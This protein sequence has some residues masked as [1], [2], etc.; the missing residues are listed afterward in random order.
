[1]LLYA[2]CIS[3][4]VRYT[5]NF[6]FDGRRCIGDLMAHTMVWKLVYSK[7]DKLGSIPMLNKVSEE[8]KQYLIL[9]EPQ[10]VVFARVL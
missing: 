3:F 9:N 7:F 2:L 5:D 1:M 4:P 10:E 8:S 6:R